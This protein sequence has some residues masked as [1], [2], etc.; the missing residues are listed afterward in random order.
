ME[1]EIG[2]FDLDD[3]CRERQGCEVIHNTEGHDCLINSWRD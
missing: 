2:K 1:F 3:A